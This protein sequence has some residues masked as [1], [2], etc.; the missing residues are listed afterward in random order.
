MDDAA[1]DRGGRGLGAILHA[2]LAQ[3]V[4]HV[5]LDGVLGDGQR[6]ADLFVG[7]ALDDQLQD[8]HFSRAQVGAGH[9]G[10][11]GGGDG[12]RQVSPAVVHGADGVQ[13]L[14][15]QNVFGEVCQIGRASCR[16]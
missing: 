14:V 11:Q 6:V 3:D 1:L 9:L 4:L 7:E 5:V 16:E 8:L 10:G 12:G 15:V 13:Q 2:E